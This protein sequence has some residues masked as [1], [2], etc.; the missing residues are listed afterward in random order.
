MAA[1]WQRCGDFVVTLGIALFAYVTGRFNRRLDR[2]RQ[3]VAAMNLNDLSG[4][5]GMLGRDSVGVLARAFDRMA[6]RLEAEQ[7]V[8]RNLFADSG[9]G[10]S[11]DRLPHIFERFYRGDGARSRPGGGTGLGLAIVR[12]LVELHSG[13]IQVTSERGQGT[14]FTIRLP[15]AEA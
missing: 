6:D 9:E 11:A 14:A 15:G 10:I 13:S 7:R 8:R 3:A 2:L 12:S 1:R 4:R 5:F